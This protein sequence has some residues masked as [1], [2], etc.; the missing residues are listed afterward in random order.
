LRAKDTAPFE[1]HSG[2]KKGTSMTETIITIKTVIIV[3]IFLIPFYL[4]A[5]HVHLAN[6]VNLKK[7]VKRSAR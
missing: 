3:V 2:F 5:V 6:G 1:G 7:G 4:Q